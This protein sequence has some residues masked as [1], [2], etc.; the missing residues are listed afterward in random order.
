MVF[1]EDRG[2]ARR[3]LDALRSQYKRTSPELAKRWGR[4]RVGRPD[5]FS[6][7]QCGVIACAYDLCIKKREI[8]QALG[9]DSTESFESSPYKLIAR[10]VKRGRKTP[11]YSALKASLET[12]DPRQQKAAVLTRLKKLFRPRRSLCEKEVQGPSSAAVFSNLP[13][14]NSP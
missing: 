5:L 8:L 7:K 9:L 13:F 6:D 2:R 1:D 4:P 12:K 3:G 14:Q 11:Q 10:A